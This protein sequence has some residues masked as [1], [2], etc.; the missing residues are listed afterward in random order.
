MHSWFVS[1]DIDLVEKRKQR[2]SKRRTTRLKAKEQADSPNDIP[3]GM[4]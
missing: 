2:K 4:N 3:T 1:V